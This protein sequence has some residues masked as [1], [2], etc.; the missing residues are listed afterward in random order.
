MGEYMVK[1]V[2]AAKIE[3]DWIG[4]IIWWWRYM[5]KLSCPLKSRIIPWLALANRLLTWDNG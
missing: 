2:Y 3:E 4:A 1:L 5:W